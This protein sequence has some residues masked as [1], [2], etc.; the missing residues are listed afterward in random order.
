[1]HMINDRSM[2][3]WDPIMMYTNFNERKS[4]K[5][6]PSHEA[7][8]T[9]LARERQVKGLCELKKI[10]EK[11]DTGKKGEM[12]HVSL[13]DDS[14]DDLVAKRAK[15][16]DRRSRS[17]LSVATLRRRRCSRQF[18]TK[19]SMATFRKLILRRRRFERWPMTAA[20]GNSH[21]ACSAD[22]GISEPQLASDLHSRADD[23]CS[24]WRLA[25]GLLN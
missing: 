23:R 19:V 17:N 9:T 12:T 16:A 15:G 21:R 20:N 22:D 7:V 4:Q 11:K 10:V 1:M 24:E 8:K 3:A 5:L 14:D 18:R 6:K 13:S 2:R 25:S